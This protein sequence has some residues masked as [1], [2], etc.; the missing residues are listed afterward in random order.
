[1]NKSHSS[2]PVKRFLIVTLL[3]VM[4]ITMGSSLVKGKNVILNINGREKT[5]LT[6]SATVEEL[7]TKEKIELKEKDLVEPKKS[8]KIEEGMTI[9]IKSP[10]SITIYDGN[11]TV[12][13]EA[14]G[15]TTEEVLEYL[16]IKLNELDRTEPKL[17]EL[18]DNKI[19]IARVTTETKQVE[20]VVPF[21]VLENL[22]KELEKGKTNVITPG[23][24]GKRIDTIETTYVNGKLEGSQIL[25]SDVVV[26]PITEVREV[27]SKVI[28]D[29]IPAGE[30]KGEEV[31]AVYIMEAT[32][33]DPTAG[34][35]TAMGT[36]ARVG[37]VAVDPR[38]IKLGSR[39]YVES[40][41][42]WPSYG[43]ATAEDTGGAIKG[44]RIDLFFNTNAQA[45]RFGRRNVKV[46]VL[47]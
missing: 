7:I 19:T 1:M 31:V 27:G 2:K 41:D 47:K 6:Y 21:N 29:Q 20:E 25:S 24:D 16:G 32:A 13:E 42:G 33:Y 45:L 5:L 8:S 3:L 43:Y 36:K 38:V 18:V 12:I 9:Y 28:A 11:K 15:D 4:A 23:V 35:K 34:S 26:E 30:F 37:A 22:N 10:R 46:Y 17:D 39:L 40:M 14:Q 44:K